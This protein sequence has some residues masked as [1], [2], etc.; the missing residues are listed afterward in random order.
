MNNQNENVREVNLRPIVS[1]VAVIAIVAVAAV[2]VGRLW[3]R[4]TASSEELTVAEDAKVT[5]LDTLADESD[6]EMEDALLEDAYDAGYEDAVEAIILEEAPEVITSF[7]FTEGQL[8]PLGEGENECGYNS[9]EPLVYVQDSGEFDN[10]STHFLP[11]DGHPAG[12]DAQFN[13]WNLS[14]ILPTLGIDP[15]DPDDLAQ[16]Y[17]SAEAVNFAL[18]QNVELVG[19]QMVLTGA[20]EKWNAGVTLTID[21]KTLHEDFG[22]LG[23]IIMRMGE[24]RIVHEDYIDGH[25]ALRVRHLTCR[26]KLDSDGSPRTVHF[27]LADE[28]DDIFVDAPF[29]YVIDLVP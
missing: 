20:F 17:I 9:Q 11:V 7:S 29:D 8:I 19:G 6:V 16:Y 26:G 23:W 5:A 24:F 22:G 21:L 13:A 4:F 1:W 14:E 18:A 3:N 28:A 15:N 10:D 27:V 2:G 12:D 25:Q